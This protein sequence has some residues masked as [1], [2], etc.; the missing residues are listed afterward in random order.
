MYRVSVQI[1]DSN[2]NWLRFVTQPTPA[3]TTAQPTP[4][5]P[6]LC[7]DGT[8]SCS[9]TDMTQCSCTD[10]RRTLLKGGESEHNYKQDLDFRLNLRM[11]AKKTPSPVDQPSPPP[12]SPPVAPTNPVRSQLLLWLCFLFSQ[13]I[14]TYITFVFPIIST[15]SPLEIQPMNPHHR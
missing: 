15:C 9:T 13:K 4:P 14:L 6:G 12:T 10:R 1:V 2:N 7:S 8:G 3:P 5:L 11:L